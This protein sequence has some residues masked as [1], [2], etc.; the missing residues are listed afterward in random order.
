MYWPIG[1]PKVY[2]LS[3]YAQS[4][5][6]LETDDDSVAEHEVNVAQEHGDGEYQQGESR[7]RSTRKDSTSSQQHDE[8]DIVAAEVS[9]GGSV[10]FT[11][12]KSQLFV[13][14]TK[15]VVALA[16]IIRSPQSLRAYGPNIALLLRPDALTVT[17]QTTLGFLITYSLYTDPSARIYQTRVVGDRK[18]ARRESADGT[19]SYRRPSAAGL[20]V[21][22]G[23]GD[24][25]REVSL[26][27]RMVIRIDAGIHTA[28]SLDDELM[29]ATQKPPAVQCI[30]W[31][32][33][34]SKPQTSTEIFSRMSWFE[35][36]AAVT[37]MLHDRPMKLNVWLTNDGKGYAVQPIAPTGGSFRGFCFHRPETRDAY[38][39]HVSVSSRFSLIAV[40]R[41][42]GVIDAYVV[43]DYAGN[44]A[45]SH[46]Y[47]LPV[48]ASSA[49]PLKCTSFSPDGHCLFAA[50]G[51]GWVFWSIYGKVCATSFVTDDASTIKN[52]E[53]WL[54][55][56][57]ACF[58]IGAGCELALIGERDNRIW[59]LDIAR[60][61]AISCTTPSNISRSLLQ[62]S[63]SVMIYRGHDVADLTA[64][65]SDV[66]LWHT[67]QIPNSYLVN[68]WPI[69]I[70][71]TSADGK[72]IAIAGRR[73]LAHFSVS[74]GK[75]K[76][77]DHTANEFEFA[78][79]GG[80]CWYH[81]ILITCVEVG[82]KQQIRLYSREKA[83]DYSH[84]LHTESLSS[85]AVYATTTGTDSLLV[86]TQENV[87]LHYIVAPNKS[88]FKLV[89][90]GQIG[91]HGII[92]S[93]ARVRAI[94]W[95]LPEEQIEYGE[96]SQD[97]ATASVLFMVD[98]K[99]V[100]LQPSTNELGEV[101]YDMRVI[102][103]NVEFFM[104]ARDQI[105]GSTTA[106]S[107]QLTPS[108]SSEWPP[109]QAVGHSLRDSLWCCDGGSLFVWP[110]VQD[111]L[112]SAPAD[113]GRELPPTVRTVLDFYPMSILIT[114]GIIHGLDA[115]LVQRRDVDFSFYRSTPRT[116]LFLPQILRY[117]LAEYNSPVA[118]HLARSYEHLPYLGHALEMLLHQVLDS[119]VDNPPPAAET[120]LL[121][122]TVSFLSTFPLYLD[123]VVNCTRKTELRSWRTLF[124]NLPPVLTLF[125]QS[126]A[127]GKLKTASG[128]LLV[129]YAL[130]A[131]TS[132]VHEFARLLQ[133][134]VETEDWELCREL[135]R[136]LL[137]IDSSGQTLRA[138]LAEAAI[139][140]TLASN[141]ATKRSSLVGT[142]PGSQGTEHIL[143]QRVN[144]TSASKNDDYFSAGHGKHRSEV[145]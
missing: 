49:G 140:S 111:V 52:D 34:D 78:V 13:W 107:A 39:T 24:G 37:Q 94:S 141:G 81:H 32:T 95:L 132:Q 80:L 112:A 82:N 51:N 66:A 144:G 26:R 3:R 11:A 114:K 29:V 65:S 31:A 27:F 57:R 98:G 86:Y 6:V 43:K 73:G 1:T 59:V 135:A 35:G 45:L 93:P 89:Q 124:A 2:S 56:I 131:N 12:T 104:L 97:V 44:I 91:F 19:N 10:F 47:Q 123:I 127:Q 7:T 64:L 50:Y 119:E 70:A 71:V 117:H 143:Q 17:V 9:R 61:A 79:R 21:G 72:Y 40:G 108:A 96:P 28:L 62:S 60:N 63:D 133:K 41:T 134:A 48:L 102:A 36:K 113:L 115:T 109:N 69:R 84:I 74:S 5:P 4:V 42:D 130:Q 83:L 103:N 142:K 136:F 145:P 23:E 99:L 110:D 77:F 55:D 30:R 67:V 105:L 120:S 139:D 128:Y 14:Q 85:P 22:P 53:H 16:A 58:W 101:K 15:P 106:P 87:L 122:T 88:S 76:T 116:Q 118:L 75:W 138:A 129:L 125:E 100:L 18:H 38:A 33:D 90:V 68:Q 126:L 92:R 46:Q 137:G 54:R 121:S 25:I 8:N 20:D